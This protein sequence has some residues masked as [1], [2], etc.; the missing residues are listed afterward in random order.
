MTMASTTAQNAPLDRPTVLVA[1]DHG[2]MLSTVVRLLSTDYDVVA[3]V[4]DGPA[5][6]AAVV[7]HS[8]DLVVLDI[9]MPAMSGIAVARVLKEGGSTSKFLFITM[10]NDRH[11]VQELRELDS[12]G[13]V[14]KDRLASDLL[15]AVREVLAGRPFVSPSAL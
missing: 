14:V 9:A 4:L 6:V 5:A 7:R 15:L 2:A 12:V 3:A 1:D 10:H 11:Y 8:P 13:F